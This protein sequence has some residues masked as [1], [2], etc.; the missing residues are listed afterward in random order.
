[1]D[2]DLKGNPF[3]SVVMPVYNAEKFLRAAIESIIR[4]TYRDFELIIV[5]DGS[6]D[7][8][9]SIILSYHDPRIVFV[10]SVKN[11]GLVAAMDASLARARGI[12][13]VRAD[14]DDI[15]MPTRIE[16][17]VR[18]MEEHPDVGAV[19]AWMLTTG[20][21]E[22][23]LMRSF[24]E[25]EDIRANLLFNTSIAQPASCIR[26]SVLKS[27]GL[28]YG[29]AFKDGAEDYDLW[30]RMSRTTKLA[31]LPRPLVRYRLHS[32]NVST[33]RATANQV[34]A[35]AIRRRQLAALGIAPTEEELSLHSHITSPGMGIPQFLEAQERWLEK[36]MAANS[37]R[38]VYA[39]ESLK[40]VIRHRWFLL[41]DAN[42]RMGLPI[43]RYAHRS[44]FAFTVGDI[45]IVPYAKFVLKAFLGR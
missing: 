20:T 39:D 23:Y 27:P 12:Y 14:A 5:N 36:L 15:S 9:R 24:T 2:P 41:C 43:L 19:S 29:P 26:T 28:G 6:T 4:Q 18:F 21:T 13:I 35:R 37:E 33:V 38:R 7:T 17:Q 32:A 44:P 25:P 10:D 1:M 30:T 16:E 45:G 3:V 22:G 42:S 31:C 8:S 11:G 40:K 34:N